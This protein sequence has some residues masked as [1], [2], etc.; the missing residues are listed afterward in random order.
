MQ[1]HLATLLI[2]PIA[3]HPSLAKLFGGI[4][5]AI[6]WQQLHYWSDKGNREDGFIY[7]T[8]DNIEK[9]TTLTRRQQDPVRKK[10]EE[11]GVLE[12]KNIKVENAPTL[13]Y[14]VNVA[15][16]MA[17]LE[18]QE[19]EKLKNPISTKGTNGKAHN[20]LMEKYNMYLSSITES[21]T[22]STTDTYV[23]FD[24][25]W[26]QYPR[27]ENKQKARTS[28]NSKKFSK[29]TFDSI[30]RFISE[31][32]SSERW[33]KNKGQYI[34]HATTFLNGKRW[35]DDIKAYGVQSVN[36]AT[37]NKYAHLTKTTK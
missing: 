25:F 31:A 7:K 4:N 23:C 37:P 16:V 22:E 6:Y 20:V 35:T 18:K 5:E 1:Q 19:K 33:T 32:K 34:P 29:E 15:K 26:E 12:V 9:E 2:R 17:L 30:M 11:L 28:F 21:T 8:K 14:R 36:K 3:F 13:H 24:K 10:L 27:K